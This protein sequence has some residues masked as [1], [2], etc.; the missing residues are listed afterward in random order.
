MS[1]KDLR[2]RPTGRRSTDLEAFELQRVILEMNKNMQWQARTI[3]IAHHENDVTWQEC[4]RTLCYRTADFL[5]KV[6]AL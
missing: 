5:R 4:K 1:R 3:H 6:R 2:A